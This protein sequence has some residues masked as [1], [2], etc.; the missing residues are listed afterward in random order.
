[1]RLDA[2]VLASAPSPVYDSLLFWAIVPVGV[3]VVGIVVP[4]F[5]W[6]VGPPR[7]LVTYSVLGTTP[8]LSGAH[9]R[10]LRHAQLQV[11]MDGS[12]LT[13][14]YVWFLRVENHSRRDIRSSDFDQEKPLLFDLG[15]NIAFAADAGSTIDYEPTLETAESSI[16]V[17]PML[18]PGGKSLQITIITE[19]RPAVTCPNPPLVG[20]TVKEQAYGYRKSRLRSG[21]I[22]IGFI[23]AALLILSVIVRF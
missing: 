16:S 2:P 4:V 13:D 12:P 10:V 18:M 21:L 3:A 15:A 5:L 1:M 6:R 20:V 23:L 7:R 11:V 9:W 8:L 17:G 14:P 22:A 19:R